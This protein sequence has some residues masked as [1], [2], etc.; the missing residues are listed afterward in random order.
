M[1]WD[2]AEIEIR[3]GK[4]TFSDGLVETKTQLCK[5]TIKAFYFNKRKAKRQLNSALRDTLSSGYTRLPISELSSIG[6]D[7]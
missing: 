6:S 4:D 1:I 5:K 2:Q 7:T 3:G